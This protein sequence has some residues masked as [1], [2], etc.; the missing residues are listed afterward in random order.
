[1]MIQKEHKK[2]LERERFYYIATVPFLEKSEAD[3]LGSIARARESG[4][5]V[6]LSLENPDYGPRLGGCQAG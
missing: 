1:M 4:G 6:L 3:T 5:F 2:H